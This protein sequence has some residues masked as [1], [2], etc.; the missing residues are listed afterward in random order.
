MSALMRAYVCVRDFGVSQSFWY[1]YQILFC[2]DKV[3]V[4]VADFG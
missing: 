3:C 1:S 2:R 4:G